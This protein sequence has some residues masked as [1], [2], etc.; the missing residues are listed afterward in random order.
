VK[1]VAT[2][3]PETNNTHILAGAAL[4]VARPTENDEAMEQTM[5]VHAMPEP[6]GSGQPVGPLSRAEKSDVEVRLCAATDH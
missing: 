1:L 6:V 4:N 2:R 5:H 3:T